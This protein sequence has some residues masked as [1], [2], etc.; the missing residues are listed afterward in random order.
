LIHLATNFSKL[1]G[2]NLFDDLGQMVF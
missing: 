2:K 1:N